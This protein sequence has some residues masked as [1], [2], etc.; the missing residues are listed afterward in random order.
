MSGLSIVTR[1]LAAR[2][3][4]ALAPTSDAALLPQWIAQQRIT[5]MSPVPTML[6]LVLDAHPDWRPPP[7]LRVLLLGGA[8]ASPK[9]LARA[10]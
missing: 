1:C 10:A 7:H 9:V 5:L 8:A 4:V 2:G 3:G 6:A